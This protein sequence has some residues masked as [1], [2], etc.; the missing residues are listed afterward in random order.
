[1]SLYRAAYERNRAQV[2]VTFSASDDEAARAFARRWEQANG[3]QVLS[4][5]HKGRSYFTQG[6]KDRRRGK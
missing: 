1:M 6:G 3:V 4:L 2:G 5:R